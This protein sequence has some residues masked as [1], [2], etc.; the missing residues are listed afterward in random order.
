MDF[1]EEILKEAEQKEEQQTEAYF[2]LLLLA[3]R[4]LSHRLSTTSTKLKKNVL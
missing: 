1:I 4:K 3:I 2:D